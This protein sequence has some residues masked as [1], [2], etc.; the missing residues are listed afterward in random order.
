M[1]INMPLTF[2]GL[3]LMSYKIGTHVLLKIIIINTCKN[4]TL[5]KESST[6]EQNC[7]G[8]HTVVE[9]LPKIHCH[10]PCPP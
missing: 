10:I 9:A 2:K 8:P 5:Y 4:R 7:S 3:K 6:M 1:Y